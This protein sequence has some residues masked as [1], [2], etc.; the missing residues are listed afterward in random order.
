MHNVPPQLYYHTI[1]FGK[2]QLK[3]GGQHKIFLPKI[4]FFPITLAK[5]EIIG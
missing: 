2:K 4:K 5:T 1:S 3:M